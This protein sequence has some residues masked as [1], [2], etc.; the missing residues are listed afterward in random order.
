MLAGLRALPQCTHL[1]LPFS[2]NTVLIRRGSNLLKETFSSRSTSSSL[3]SIS[4]SF[5]PPK[6]VSK[7]G[8]Q[9]KPGPFFSMYLKCIWKLFIHKKQKKN[10]FTGN[11]LKKYS[12]IY[13]VYAA[14]IFSRRFVVSCL[15]HASFFFKAFTLFY[16]NKAFFHI[17]QIYKKIKNHDLFYLYF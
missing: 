12:C 17:F 13:T 14:H 10:L 2:S 3:I 6:A 1:V 7:V 8:A 9:K 11:F 16:A 5:I 4:S 15:D